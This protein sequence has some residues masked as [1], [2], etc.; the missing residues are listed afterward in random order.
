MPDD[1]PNEDKDAIIQRLTREAGDARKKLR[2]AEARVAALEDAGPKA[3]EAAKADGAAEAR[4]AL[5]TE[6]AKAI[7]SAEVRALAARRLAD[8]DD[9]PRFLD[10]TKVVSADGKVDKAA[11]ERE[12]A[13]LVEHKPYLAVP[14]GPTGPPPPPPGPTGSADGGVRPGSASTNPDAPMNDLMRKALRH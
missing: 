10:M 7:A 1:P 13:E 14:T 5:A 3:I 2:E 6:H 11:I 4:A 8:P 9:A 12:L